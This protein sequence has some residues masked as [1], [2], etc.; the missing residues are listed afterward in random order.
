MLAA[1]PSEVRSS[2]G[3]SFSDAA[4]PGTL[5]VEA[6][7]IEA[8]V[9]PARRAGGGVGV[10]VYLADELANGAGYCRFLSDPAELR[11]GLLQPLGPGGAIR[12]RLLGDRHPERCDA[13]CA[14]CLRDYS[15]AASHAWLDWR[16]GL[17]LAALAL[18]S[19]WRPSLEAPY[20]SG[21][22][23]RAARALAAALRAPAAGE[24]V[25]GGAWR[26]RRDSAPSVVIVH[27]L[28]GRPPG[29]HE[30]FITV[31]DALRRP[32]WCVAMAQ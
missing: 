18:D 21:A 7:E 31:F 27:P 30:V 23:E 13:S 1:P 8:G 25:D 29:P 6:R 17:D 14:D 22:A 11:R 2:P 5:E 15:T 10:E 20:W 12:E 26:L 16:L 3:L 24:L 32:G 19:C 28:E 4:Q 9:R